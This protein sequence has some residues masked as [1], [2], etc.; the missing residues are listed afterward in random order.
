[1]STFVKLLPGLIGAAA[2]FIALKILHLFG[3]RAIGFEIAVFTLTY[4]IVTLGLDKALAGYGAER[5]R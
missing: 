5:R 4:V 3:I 2:A 1:M